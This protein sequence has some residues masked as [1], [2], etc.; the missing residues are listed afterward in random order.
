MKGGDPERP[1]VKVKSGIV[2]NW[3]GSDDAGRAELLIG[4][5]MVIAGWRKPTE[6][7][8]VA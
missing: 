1:L 5:T 4:S 2:R 8:E 3:L 6:E 7:L